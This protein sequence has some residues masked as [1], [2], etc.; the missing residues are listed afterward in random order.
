MAYREINEKAG[1]STK[2]IA[3]GIHSHYFIIHISS[4]LLSAYN[5]F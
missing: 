5:L 1:D 3:M 2:D 4:I